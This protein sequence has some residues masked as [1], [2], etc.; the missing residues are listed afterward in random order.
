MLLNLS[1]LQFGRLTAHDFK[2]VAVGKSGRRM[3][4][5]QCQCE[6]G[7]TAEVLACHLTGGKI[8]SCGCLSAEKSSARFLRNVVANGWHKQRQTHGQSRTREYSVWSEMIGRCHRPSAGAFKWYGARGVR[9]CD[10]WRYG[11]DGVSG[12]ECFMRDMGPRPK[13]L[14]ID[15]IKPDGDYEPDNCRWA[16]WDDQAA[17]RRRAA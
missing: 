5:W 11:E 1:G 14:T 4:T 6:C 16:T 17:N 3:V 7:N 12:F 8:R 13:G 10:R 9:V 15:R 2:F